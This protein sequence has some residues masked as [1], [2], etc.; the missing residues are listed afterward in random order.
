[1]KTNAV[2]KQNYSKYKSD[3]AKEEREKKTGD[4]TYSLWHK[5]IED[6]LMWRQQYWNGDKNWDNAYRMYRGKHYRDQDNDDPTS[7]D[8]RDLITVNI[9]GSTIQNIG[10]FLMNGEAEFVLKPRKPSSTVSAMIQQSVLNYEWKQRAMQSQVRKAVDDCMI[11]GH[12]IIRTGFTLEIDEA[13]KAIDGDIVYSDYIKEESP[14]A[15]RVSPKH[16]L[17]DPTASEKNLETARWCAEIFFVPVPDILANASYNQSVI[18]D[19]KSGKYTIQTKISLNETKLNDETCEDESRNLGILYEIWDKK[20]RKYYVFAKGVQEPLVEKDWPYPYLKGFPYKMVSFI[21]IPDEPYAVGIPYMIQDQQYELN[22][23]RSS[24]FI[25]TRI[26]NRKYEV[27]K[28]A[29]D[30]EGLD[31]LTQGED[32]TIV[33]VNAPGAIRSIQD[34]S[35]PS[36]VYQQEAIIKEDVRQLTGADAL[37]QGGNLPSRTTAGEVNARSNI[38]RAKLDDRIGAIDTFVEEIGSQILAHIKANYLTDKIIKIVGQQ[39]EYWVKYTTEDIQDDVDI[40][41][42]SIAAP[43]TDPLLER[44]QALQILQIVQ[45]LFPLIQ[46]GQIKIN[47]NEL[48]KWVLEKFDIKDIGRFFPDGLLPNPPLQEISSQSS[49]SNE[50]QQP[51]STEIMSVQDLQKQAGLAPLMN[52]SGLQL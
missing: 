27:L 35:L 1:M 51:N 10:P 31:A 19:I 48:F 36:D 49:Q 47:L 24:L 16:F 4:F 7:D 45:G 42:D 3:K 33:E 26:F 38:F 28:G 43:K 13:V 18:N 21:P 6:T 11:I 37:I 23:K 9:T 14:Y 25:H 20:Y 8:P 17:F 32:G 5:R 41:M 34:A 22:R 2:L 52:S 29:V 39:G 15:R 12:G 50:L 40:T 30:D 46:A 44:Q